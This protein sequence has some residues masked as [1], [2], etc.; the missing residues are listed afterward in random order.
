VGSLATIP[1]QSAKLPVSYERAREALVQCHQIDECKQWADKAAALASY[2][3]QAQDDTLF[4]TAMKIQ[5]RAI[6]RAGELLSEIEPKPGTRTDVQPKVV[7]GH[8]LPVPELDEMRAGFV[9]SPAPTSATGRSGAAIP[10]VVT[11]K[12][13]AEEA[14]LSERQAKTALRIAAIPAAEFEE[15]IEAPKPPTITEL[16][17]RGTKPRPQPAA[18]PKPAGPPAYLCGRTPDEFNAA[19][20]ARGRVRDLAVQCGRVSAEAVAVTSTDTERTE[21]RAWLS[22]IAPWIAALSEAL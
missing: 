15:A 13:A 11:R 14:G 8:R 19:I 22:D 12:S 7:A 17:E 16:A 4:Q 2:A 5:G 9:A 21:L 20:H 1:V 18:A 6:R 3:K 10:P